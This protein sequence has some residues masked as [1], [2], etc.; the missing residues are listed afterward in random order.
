MKVSEMI[1]RLSKIDPQM[2]VMILDLF[3]AQGNP[4]TINF[5]PKERVINE[6]NAHEAADCEGRVG[7]KVMVIGYGCY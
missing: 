6:K 5:G 2:E 3:N 1:N 4:R 7:E